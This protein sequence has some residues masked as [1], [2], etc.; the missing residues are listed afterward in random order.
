MTAA[1]A[2]Q[3]AA[4]FSP[5][6]RL[7]TAAEWRLLVGRTKYPWGDEA[8]ASRCRCADA[9]G[10]SSGACAVL[11]SAAPL[12]DLSPFGIVGLA[13]NV[14]E[15]CRDGK[16]GF[17]LRGGSYESDVANCAADFVPQLVPEKGMRT[18]GF[19]IAIPQKE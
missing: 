13:G 7:P 10:K 4:K 6:A 11:E 19:R 15:W 12:K 14:S 2:D 17:T 8:D 18:I 1:Q 16:G 5:R 3:W 9:N